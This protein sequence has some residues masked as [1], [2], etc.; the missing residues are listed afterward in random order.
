MPEQESIDR[1]R[2]L[3]EFVGG[4]SKLMVRYRATRPRWLWRV[5]SP[6]GKPTTRL[7]ERYGPEVRRGPFQGTKFSKNSLG[8]AN[9]L[10]AKVLGTYEPEIVRFLADH[11]PSSATFVDIG[12]GEGFFCMGVARSGPIRVIGF[13]TNRFERKLALENAHV[14]GVKIEL[15]GFADSEALS[16]LP[17]GKLLLLSDI[18]GFEEDLLDPETSPRLLTATMA[19]EIHEHIRPNVVS[20]LTERFR[21][22]HVIE[23]IGMTERSTDLPELAGWDEKS[24]ALAVN[25]GHLARDGWMT[26]VPK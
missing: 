20:V 9:Y 26:F 23:R 7:V 11:V 16:D 14:N 24:A 6:F 3:I 12:S 22:S 13:E 18:E 2:R 21:D 8:H 5:T 10:A 17:D 25:D 15:R 19:V 4:Y 1:R